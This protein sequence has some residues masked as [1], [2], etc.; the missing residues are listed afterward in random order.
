M[1]PTALQFTPQTMRSAGP[2]G[3]PTPSNTH[4]S[5]PAA[6]DETAANTAPPEYRTVLPVNIVRNG[7]PEP[8]AN[9]QAQNSA[10]PTFEYVRVQTNSMAAQYSQ[11]PPGTQF[12]QSGPPAFIHTVRNPGSAPAPST[13]VP[14][15]PGYAPPTLQPQIHFA[16][17]GSS[18][19]SGLLPPVYLSLINI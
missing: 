12:A 2:P 6:A 14:G 8:L 4:D 19:P 16:P 15:T 3:F 10:T 11:P 5:A 1:E 18:N 17:A 13:Y 9:S 7:A